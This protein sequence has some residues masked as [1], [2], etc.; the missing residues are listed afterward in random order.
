MT[1]DIIVLLWWFIAAAVQVF[2][3]YIIYRYIVKILLFVLFEDIHGIE[4]C[5]LFLF[6]YGINTGKHIVKLKQYLSVYS[7]LVENLSQ[8]DEIIMLMH[9]SQQRDVLVF[10]NCFII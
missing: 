4:E 2:I 7:R 1:I 3:H 5:L 8:E 10:E 6:D 9:C